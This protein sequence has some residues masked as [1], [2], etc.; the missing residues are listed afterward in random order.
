MNW[1]HTAMTLTLVAGLAAGMTSCKSQEKK[2]AEA[3]A[4]IEAAA[5]G[6][7]VV[8]KDGVATLSGEMADE[9]AKTAAEE[10]AKKVEGVKSV[11]NQTTVAPPPAPAPAPVVVNPDDSLTSAATAAIQ[12]YPG[13]T[14]TVKD[15]VVTLNGEIKKADLP[16][17]MQKV[18]EIKP[19]KV[20]N[21][22]TVK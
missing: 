17:L 19:K 6:V 22:M 8:V 15:G 2:D 9:A 10:A 18:N 12:E 16:K 20:E 4:K 14:V 3:K 1:K 7:T 11:V 13:V 5:P 21:K